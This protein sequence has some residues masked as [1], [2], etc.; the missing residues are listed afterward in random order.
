MKRIQVTWQ[1]EDGYAGGARPQHA[2]VYLDN[3]EA[4][5]S[6][7]EIEKIIDDIV[8]EDFQQRVTPSVR[9]S[10]MVAAI[11]AIRAEL[12]GT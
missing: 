11:A 9:R 3:F 6:D 10:D 7:E 4:G 2:E 8:Q 5:M 12:A 1:A